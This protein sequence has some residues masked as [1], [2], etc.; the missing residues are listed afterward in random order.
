MRGVTRLVEGIHLK[1][2]F[3][4]AL[5]MR[6]VTCRFAVPR[7]KADISTRTP[8][9]GSDAVPVG[10]KHVWVVISTRTPHAGSDFVFHYVTVYINIS[11]RTPHAGSDVAPFE[12][13]IHVRISTRTPHA[14]R[15]SVVGGRS[16]WRSF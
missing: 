1:L 8:H 15:E 7:Y 9:A 13:G 3:Q 2:K 14:G 12:I 5:P 16:V 4:P 11:T 10:E 6:G